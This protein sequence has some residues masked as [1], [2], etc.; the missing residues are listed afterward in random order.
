MLFLYNNCR[1]RF[2][3]TNQNKNK[4]QDFAFLCHFLY[5]SEKVGEKIGA[6]KR[7]CNAFMIWAFPSFPCTKQGERH[8]RP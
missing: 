6:K 1:S 7:L 2:Q 4:K 8:Q 3:K 5:T